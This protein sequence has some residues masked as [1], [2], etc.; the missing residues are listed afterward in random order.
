MISRRFALPC[1]VF[2]LW[3]C[4]S[5]SA[6]A[7]PTVYELS[8]FINSP[9]LGGASLQDTRIGSRSNQFG[10]A[11]L[12][13]AFDNNLNAD[14]FGTVSWTI[15][16]DGT[17]LL[18]ASFY[19]FL[20]AEI[21]EPINSFF[22]E[23]GDSSGFTPGA[24]ESDSAADSWEIDEPQFAFGDIFD[25]ISGGSLDNSNGV[26]ESSPYDVS[27]ALGFD[28]GEFLANDILTATFDISAT[29]NGGLFHFDPQSQDGFYFNGSVTVESADVPVPEAASLLLLSIGLGGI[30]V[31]RR[32]QV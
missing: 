14:N 12:D 17:D 22:N 31:V 18:D 26:P 32:K 20:D 25:N 4:A 2:L 19:G 30:M 11:G 27:L 16:N 24:G 6:Y 5:S 9:T 3:C 23:Y 28:I 29:D 7:V 21:D 8:A 1:S 15:A 13:V 10:G